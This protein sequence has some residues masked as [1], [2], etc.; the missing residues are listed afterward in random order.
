MS[1][2]NMEMK[3]VLSTSENLVLVVHSTL[4]QRTLPSQWWPSPE[5]GKISDRRN[6]AVTIT[7]HERINLPSAEDWTERNLIYS[8]DAHCVMPE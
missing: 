2:R 1:S 6:E 7:P 3:K 8:L 4:A 5:L